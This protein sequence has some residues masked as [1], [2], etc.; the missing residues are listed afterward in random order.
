M[1]SFRDRGNPENQILAETLMEAA[2]GGIHDHHGESLHDSQM[3][4][5]S[6]SLFESD[7]QVSVCLLFCRILY[8]KVFAK[9]CFFPRV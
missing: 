7:R 2:E 3:L 1:S 5:Q 4:T 8:E 9:E 6:E